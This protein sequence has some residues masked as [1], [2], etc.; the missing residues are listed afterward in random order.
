MDKLIDIDLVWSKCVVSSLLTPTLIG[1]KVQLIRASKVSHWVVQTFS[2]RLQVSAGGRLHTPD[3]HF[4]VFFSNIND[5]YAA[6]YGERG[7]QLALCGVLPGLSGSGGGGPQTYFKHPC[8][9]GKH[10][11]SEFY[12]MWDLRKKK[13]ETLQITSSTHVLSH[14]HLLLVPQ[15]CLCVMSSNPGSCFAILSERLLWA[16]RSR[17]AE[18]N[19]MNWRNESGKFFTISSANFHVPSWILKGLAETL[20]RGGKTKN[21]AG[22]RPVTFPRRRRRTHNSM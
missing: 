17:E 19:K 3:P 11:K 7:F 22:T 14:Q 16:W 21:K 1:N 2:R 9:F 15:G 6:T 10:S 8:L 12:I 4:W 13:K 18:T 5:I 20:G